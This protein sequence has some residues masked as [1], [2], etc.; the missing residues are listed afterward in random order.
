[1]LSDFD[2]DLLQRCLKRSPGGWDD[3]V[4]RFLGLVVH[5][6]QHSA[7]ACSVP[8]D[9]H[10]RQEL[11][12]DV[13]CELLK[14]D[15]AV[16]RRFRGQSSLATYL[17]VIARRVV[18]RKLLAQ[19]R[20]LASEQAAAATWPKPSEESFLANALVENRDAVEA[21]LRGLSEKEAAAVRMYHFEGSGY[22]EIGAR[23]GLA[24]TSIG[25]FLS[26]AREKIRASLPQET[27]GQER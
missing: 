22:R 6:V 23:L 14:E 18:L 4:N 10:L 20:R 15:L 19:S 17:T 13:F 2:R 27:D 1:V 21:A 3:L 8:L 5:V 9:A 12:S 26:R 25:P 24:E 7:Q 16:L 11:V